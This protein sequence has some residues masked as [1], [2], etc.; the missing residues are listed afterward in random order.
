MQN[1]MVVFFYLFQTENTLFWANLI[2]KIEI[3]SLSQNSVPKINSNMQNSMVLFNVFVFNWKYHLWANLVKK[4]RLVSLSWNLLPGLIRICRIQYW[5]SLFFVHK[6][7]F[8]AHLLNAKICSFAHTRNESNLTF[9][10]HIKN[11]F[12]YTIKNKRNKETNKT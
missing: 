9:L 10:W 8:W 5:C 4:L 7:P 11:L 12:V 1:S 2:H 6:P 3:V